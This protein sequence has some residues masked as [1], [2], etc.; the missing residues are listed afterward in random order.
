[1]L[2]WPVLNL[3]THTLFLFLVPLLTVYKMKLAI[4]FSI[5]VSI[6]VKSVR[7]PTL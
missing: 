1:M 2:L 5:L 7:L 6:G 3:N 4:A